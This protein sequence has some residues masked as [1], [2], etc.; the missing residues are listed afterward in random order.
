MNDN[1]NLSKKYVCVCV[2]WP[3]LV[4]NAVNIA[5]I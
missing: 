3:R 2:R 5:D 1:N 4:P